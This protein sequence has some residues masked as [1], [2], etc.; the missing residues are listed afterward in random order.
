MPDWYALKDPSSLQSPCLLVYPERI[1][2]NIEKM[3]EMAG[4]ADTLRPHIK[5]H[6]CAEIIEMQMAKGIRKF[7]CATIA[8]AEL[9]A[10]CGAD[11]ILLAMQPVGANIGRYV[12]LIESFPQNRFSTLVDNIA[13]AEELARAAQEAGIEIGLF[14]DLN[15]GMDRTGIKPDTKAVDLFAF[16][17]DSPHLQAR[18]LHAYDG[19]LRAKNLKERTAACDQ[20]YSQVISLK[21]RIESEGRIV[22]VII[23]GGSPTFPIHARREGMEASPGTT[24]LWDARYGESFQ[25]MEF[26]PAAVLMSRIISKPATGKICLDLGHKSVAPEMNFPRV[27][28][29]NISGCDQ[30]SQSEEHL[31]LSCPNDQAFSVGDICYA[32]PMHICPTVAKYPY[33]LAVQDGRV[34]EK[35]A[36]AARDHKLTI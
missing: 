3:I 10:S 14:L 23:A 17:D 29:L 21:D 35:W 34:M 4:D 15:T 26:L 16:V 9:L 30:I 13:T 8:E 32:I 36:V 33:L 24:L 11:D 28:L 18:G 2:K 19:H 1:E 5:T 7:K 25:E 27:E 20:A 6:K 12:N 22:P 31:V